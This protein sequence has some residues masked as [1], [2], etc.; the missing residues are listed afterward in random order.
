MKLM[1][2]FPSPFSRKML[3]QNFYIDSVSVIGEWP[4]LMVKTLFCRRYFW[5]AGH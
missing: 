3:G 1:T 4:T 5:V 2:G